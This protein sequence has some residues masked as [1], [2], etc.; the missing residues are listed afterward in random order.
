MKKTILF[1]LG[2]VFCAL[3]L[4]TSCSDDDNDDRYFTKPKDDIEFKGKSLEEVREALEGTW[5]LISEDETA[6]PG[7]YLIFKNNRIKTDK[8]YDIV[9]SK[10]LMEPNNDEMHSFCPRYEEGWEYSTFVFWVP[11]HIKN[12]VLC[13]STFL[14]KPELYVYY[15]HVTDETSFYGATSF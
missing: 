4:L 13:L 12:G 15:E 9:W 8:W 5:Q 14:N 6:G 2:L 1:S 7:E 3:T 11:I 10:A